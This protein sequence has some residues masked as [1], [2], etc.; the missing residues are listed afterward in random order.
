MPTT[1]ALRFDHR[2]SLRQP[3]LILAFNGWSDAGAA[4][5][6][7][8]G[9]L[10]GQLG[11]QKFAAI[12]G[13]D[14]FDFTVQRPQVRVD[15]QQVRSLTW[16]GYDFS[17]AESPGLV[18]GVG[19]EPH[20]RWKSFCECLLALAREVGVERVALLGSFL[21]EVLY[22]DPVPLTGF[23]SDPALLERL[24][25]P[26]TG[27]EGPTGIAGAVA[28]AIRR[29]GMPL[30]SLWAAIPHYV[31]AAPNPRG[32]LALILK[33]REWANLPVDLAPLEAAAVSFQAQLVE[34][35]DANTDLSKYLRGLRKPETSH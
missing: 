4:A 22:T 31:A 1:D 7:A 3:T 11:S 12:D 6:T 17:A 16:P 9:Y 34:A 35:V 32:A 14:F 18:F 8:V 29:S 26:P 10:S 2:P 25:V 24:K 27:Y 28:D 33:L 13:E 21:A 19:P 20:L 5:S 15:Q 30:V 23:A